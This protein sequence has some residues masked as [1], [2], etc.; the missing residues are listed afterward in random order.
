MLVRAAGVGLGAG[1]EA[2]RVV[3]PVFRVAG[4]PRRV[5]RVAGSALSGRSGLRPPKNDPF[6]DN[7]RRLKERL[8]PPVGGD[9]GRVG[10]TAVLVVVSMELP[11]IL[12]LIAYRPWASTEPDPALRRFLK[13]LSESES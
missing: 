1:A 7:D 13:L 10:S 9:V 5:V 11:L 8:R 6:G 4:G 3:L 2:R 12:R